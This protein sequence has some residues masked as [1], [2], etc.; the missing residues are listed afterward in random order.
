MNP[1]Y[2]VSIKE[3]KDH[4]VKTQVAYITIEHEDKFLSFFFDGTFRLSDR[5]SHCL[6]Y[7]YDIFAVHLEFGE[8]ADLATIFW[9]LFTTVNVLR[10]EGINISFMYEKYCDFMNIGVNLDR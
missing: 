1:I 2:P 10:Y 7:M 5:G 9:P 4:Y 3:I 8:K 6:D